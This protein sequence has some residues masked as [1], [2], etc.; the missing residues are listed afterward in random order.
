MVAAWPQ[1]SC[2]VDQE[3]IGGTGGTWSN[4]ANW[5]STTGFPGE[6]TATLAGEGT[7][8][9]IAT[10]AA[11]NAA[12]NFGINMSTMGGQ[13]SL[14]AVDWNKTNTAATVL[15][16]ISTT[17]SGILQLNGAPR[18]RQGLSGRWFS[19]TWG[20]GW[21]PSPL[22]CFLCQFAAA[23][24]L[25]VFNKLTTIIGGSIRATVSQHFHGDIRY[26]NPGI[27][28]GF[29]SLCG[30]ITGISHRFGVVGWGRRRS[31]GANSRSRWSRRRGAGAGA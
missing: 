16:N 31:R 9:D 11:A 3:W 19:L 23:L 7:T 29:F 21:G 27:G 20:R 4:S 1:I 10:V 5:T 24:F 6:A 28:G 26:G 30:G 8:T 14:G 2:A 17:V 13:L 22:R 25:F 15:G 12:T 18:A